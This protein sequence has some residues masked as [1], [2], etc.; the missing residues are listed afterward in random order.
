[1]NQEM[2]SIAERVRGIASKTAVEREVE[3]VHAEVAGSK[4]DSVVRIFIDKHDGL[5]IEDCSG[6]SHAVEA[7]FDAEDFI[8]G[9]YVLE[10]SSPGIERELY[11][12]ADFVRFTGE[13]ARVKLKCEVS[14][15]KNFVGAIASVTGD[16]IEITDRTIG[17]V[18]F[19]YGLVAK[20]NLKLDLGKE[21]GK[22]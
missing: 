17:P 12:L 9:T 19:G 14:G 1:M 22:R 13:L 11:S 7:V 8:P 18:Q 20:A 6:F 3:F 5:T 15:Q 21:L 16:E 10:V 4:R 2:L